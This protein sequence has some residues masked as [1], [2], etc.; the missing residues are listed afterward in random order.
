M[1]LASCMTISPE[2]RVPHPSGSRQSHLGLSRGVP[3][4]WTEVDEEE[5]DCPA[6]LRG[7]VT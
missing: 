6:S 5:D 1:E 3:E 4:E 7:F 2:D